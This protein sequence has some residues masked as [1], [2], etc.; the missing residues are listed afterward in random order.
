VTCPGGKKD[1]LMKDILRSSYDKSA[2]SYDEKFRDIQYPKY[3]N[4]IPKHIEA[5]KKAGSIL[6]MGCGTGLLAEY[7]GLSGVDAGRITGTDFSDGMLSVARR[8][9]IRCV[10]CDIADMDFPEDSFD[11]VLSFTVMRIFEGPD[12]PEI[13]GG[14][15]RILRDGGLF[16]VTVLTSRVDASWSGLFEGNGF[17]LI[18]RTDCFQDTGFVYVNRK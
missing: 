18:D 7:L 11:A 17:Q 15:K 2:F 13:V 1:D 3:E 5:L 4:I 16:I 14:V 8:R 9:G 10:K 12:E 6:D